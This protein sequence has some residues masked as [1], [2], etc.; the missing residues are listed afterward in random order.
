[1]S[2]EIIPLSH[3]FT[4]EKLDFKLPL[5][6]EKLLGKKFVIQSIEFKRSTMGKLAI[7]QTSAGKYRT[8]SEVLINQLQQLVQIME[9]KNVEFE[10]TLT[11][12]ESDSG[13]FYQVFE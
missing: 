2:K 3:V 11:E 1:M 5:L 13:L 8:S 7:V 10:V 12:V 9:S 4:A 6:G